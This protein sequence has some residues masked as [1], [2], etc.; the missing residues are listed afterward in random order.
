MAVIDNIVKIMSEKGIT[1]Y[2]LEKDTGINAA[3]FTHWKNGTQPTAEKLE[4]IIEYMKVSPNQI[5]G[6]ESEAFLTENEQE[7]LEQ[8]RKLSDRDQVKF[9]GR[10]EEFTKERGK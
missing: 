4:R 10:I 9:I 8:F 6:Y 3:T 2:K 7:L 5:F 1:A